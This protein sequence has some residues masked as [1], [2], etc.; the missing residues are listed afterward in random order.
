KVAHYRVS[1]GKRVAGAFAA[2][3][4]RKRPRIPEFGMPLSPGG[5]GSYTRVAGSAAVRG[6]SRRG[7][8]SA[9]FSRD[10]AAIGRM[11]ARKRDVLRVFR[12]SRRERSCR[13]AVLAKDV[14]EFSN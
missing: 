8:Q 12:P 3:T 9:R 4:P 1:A 10:S 13:P 14:L 2:R 7:R 11:Q 5:D 6:R